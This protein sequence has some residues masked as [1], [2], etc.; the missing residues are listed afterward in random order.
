MEKL[1]NEERSDNLRM[2]F[3]EIILIFSYLISKNFETKIK[4]LFNWEHIILG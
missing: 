1:N 4:G 3:L 2:Y